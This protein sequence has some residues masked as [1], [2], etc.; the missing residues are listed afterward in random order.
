MFQRVLRRARRFEEKRKEE[1][2]D[3]VI[4][5]MLPR[6]IGQKTDTKQEKR[7]LLSKLGRF[8]GRR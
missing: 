4:L 5:I 1:I 6:S 3:E 7:G 8:F 2:I